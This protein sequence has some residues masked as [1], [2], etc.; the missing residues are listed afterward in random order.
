MSQTGILDTRIVEF[1]KA[2]VFDSAGNEI[3]IH[4]LWQNQ[5]VLF[6]FLRHFACIECRT[7]AR[8]IWADRERY[9]KSGSKIVFIGNGDPQFIQA[10]KEDL[11]I[12]NAPIYTD[13]SLNV[14]KAAGFRRNFLAALGPASIK[15]G[16]KMFKEGNR[17]GL[18][19]KGQGDLW[20]LGGVLVIAS[21]GRVKYKFVSQKLGDFPPEKDLTS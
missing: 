10:F 1:A 11:E 12:Q 5:A 13:P 8:Q 3:A 6:I 18:Y 21:D 17:Q 15:A 7:F 14:F 16:L 20:Q 2:R 4:K 9:E 19:S